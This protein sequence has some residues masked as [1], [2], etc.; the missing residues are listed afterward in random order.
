MASEVNLLIDDLEKI[1]IVKNLVAF[2]AAP[3]VLPLTAMLKQPAAQELIKQGMVVSERCKESAAEL[4]ELIEDLLAEANAELVTSKS[5]VTA[6]SHPDAPSSA[7]VAEDICAIATELNTQ[8]LAL[9]DGWLD[10]PTL[11]AAG[12]GLIALRQLFL[13]GV[14]LNTL[15]WYV[16][17][18]YAFDS[19]IK[20]HPPPPPQR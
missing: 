19:F 6:S 5:S 9:T 10:L 2:M 15:P 18:W 7:I 17:A 20:L 8:T 3:V 12:L 11:A 16:L 14:Q 13:K 4:N 1:A